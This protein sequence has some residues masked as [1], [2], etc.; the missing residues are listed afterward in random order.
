MKIR[1]HYLL[2]LVIFYGCKLSFHPPTQ[3]PGFN[4]E[5]TI[6]SFVLID[7]GVTSTPGIAIKKK[8][9]GV[10]KEVKDQYLVT[11][12]RVLQGQLHLTPITDTTLTAE[13]RN[14]LLQK[15]SDAIANIS[16][17]YKTAIIFIL[18]DSYSGFRQGDVKKVSSWDGNSTSKVAAYDVFF[19]TDWLIIQA[20][21]VN[22]RTVSASRFHS[23]RTITSGL[24]A[25]GPG[26]AANKKDIL[27]M[28]E[29]NAFNVSVL[30]K[31]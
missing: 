18:K 31:Y 9:E 24:L 16:K 12:T 14:K 11:L 5:P 3:P 7:G 4:I 25:R 30:F 21:A 15:D 29:Q 2:L 20:D 28:A 8:R 19:D 27:E 23:N 1:S 13:D 22:E 26:F 17:K 10:I 6:K